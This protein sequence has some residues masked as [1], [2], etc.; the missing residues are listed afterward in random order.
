MIVPEGGSM[1]GESSPNGMICD[2]SE[3]EF[4]QFMAVQVA[5][6]FIVSLS[7]NVKLFVAITDIK[8]APFLD[9]TRSKD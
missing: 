3:D 7:C 1:T 2:H 6:T 4:H 5:V 9:A 8:T